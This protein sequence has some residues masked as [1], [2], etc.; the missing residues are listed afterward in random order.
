MPGF[1]VPF[2][3]PFG[4]GQSIWQQEISALL[5]AYAPGWDNSDTSQSTAEVHALALGAA[6]MWAVNRRLEN[7]RI[8]ARM[9]ETLPRWERACQLVPQPT[10]TVQ[11]RRAA[12]AARFLGYLGNT[13]VQ[14]FNICST[15]CASVPG[16]VWSGL[17][18]ATAGSQV[19]YVPGINPGPPG[20]EWTSL[21]ATVGVALVRSGVPGAA[22]W[23]LVRRLQVELTIVCPVWMTFTIGC[24]DNPGGP[25]GGSG[26]IPG[27]A[28][29]GV[30]LI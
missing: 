6:I 12:I 30:S 2:A 19:T 25:N 4:G 10:D 1:G 8:P 20:F 22:Y 7:Q 21:R 14:I 15:L 5:D 11:M 28:I 26:C 3:R 29:P 23:D 17:V 27:V 13:P 24:L 16:A 18:A 9:L